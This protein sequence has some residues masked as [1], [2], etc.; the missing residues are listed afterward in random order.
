MAAFLYRFDDS[1]EFTA[2]AD[3]PFVDV[4]KT[5]A[6][7]RE[8][9]WLASNR[10]ERRVDD[11]LRSGVPPVPPDLARRRWRRSSTAS[12]LRSHRWT[13]RIRMPG[14]SRCRPRGGA[15]RIGSRRRR[16]PWVDGD[17]SGGRI[18]GHPSRGRLGRRD[19]AVHPRRSAGACGPGGPLRRR[20]RPWS[21]RRPRP[22]RTRW[23]PLMARWRSRRA[24]VVELRSR[25]RRHR[26]H[27]VRRCAIGRACE[28]GCVPVLEVVRLEED[29]G[30]Q[31]VDDDRRA[32]GERVT[33]GR[34]EDHRWPR[35]RSSGSTSGDGSEAGVC[36][37]DPVGDGPA[38]D[39]RPRARLD[40]K[41]SATLGK[42][43]SV[44]TFAVGPVRSS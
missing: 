44:F 14:R 39:R 42:L 13:R 33:L 22:S 43:D 35:R 18:H 10:R 7:F 17:D 16:G 31:G 1:P 3:S 30:G 19:H 20:P 32:Q 2:P 28:C 9:T 12:P 4:R 6:F 37:R 21:P 27:G 5:D 25:R 23:S 36:R 8:I 24:R 15:R 41:L 40:G 11:D 34:V 29:G 26:R 38:F